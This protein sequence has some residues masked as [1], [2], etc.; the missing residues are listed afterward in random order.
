MLIRKKFLFGIEFVF[1]LIWC[2][3]LHF[4]YYF[5]RFY[6]WFVKC[7]WDK[8]LALVLETSGFPQSWSLFC[9]SDWKQLSRVLQRW[10][11][12]TLVKLMISSVSV[13]NVIPFNRVRFQ[14]RCSFNLS[15]FFRS[16]PFNFLGTPKLLNLL[17][18]GNVLF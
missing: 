18:S 4:S 2:E 6:W 7:Y 14:R 16:L 5:G 15:G 1:S 3:I 10:S 12:R 13:L 11:K 8:R 9:I 17:V